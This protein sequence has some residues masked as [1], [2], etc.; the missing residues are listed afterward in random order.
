MY[1]L[2]DRLFYAQNSACSCLT[3][4]PEIEYHDPMCRYRLFAEARGAL[5]GVMVKPTGWM[6][7][8]DELKK[9]KNEM[10]NRGWQL[11]RHD[12]FE[13]VDQAS[14]MAAEVIQLLIDAHEKKKE[15]PS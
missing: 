9:L 7:R 3:K 1:S 2:R 14:A 12:D 5:D 11:D 4:T 10:E 13:C 8:I 15:Q 6:L